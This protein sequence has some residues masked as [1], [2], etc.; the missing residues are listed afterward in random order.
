[1]SI[2]VDLHNFCK[3]PDVKIGVKARN[4]WISLEPE[5]GE[6]GHDS[7]T[8]FFPSREAQEHFMRTVAAAFVHNLETVRAIPPA[9][10][11]ND[12]LPEGC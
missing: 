2:S 6:P 7:V 5:L 10:E 12:S 1:M 11:M 8:F 9:P 4:W 3:T